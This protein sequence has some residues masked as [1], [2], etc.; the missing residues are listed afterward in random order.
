MATRERRACF[1]SVLLRSADGDAGRAVIA[2]DSVIYFGGLLAGITVY[3]QMIRVLDEWTQG[4]VFWNVI[5]LLALGRR[6][7]RRFTKSENEIRRSSSCCRR[8]TLF[9]PIYDRVIGSRRP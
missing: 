8:S 9:K 2:A 1:A 6:V 4:H 7:W 5:I 3:R